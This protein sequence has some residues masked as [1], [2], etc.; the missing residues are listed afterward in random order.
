MGLFDFLKKK[1]FE[2]I[3]QL[4]QLLEKYK[5]IND[6]EKE[7]ERQNQ[8][9]QSDISAKTKELEKIDID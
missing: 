5:P 3:N 4:K 8:K 6:I 7:V 9:L 2:E 1:E